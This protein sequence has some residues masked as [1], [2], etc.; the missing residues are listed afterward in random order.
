MVG[1]VFIQ[2]IRYCPYLDRYTSALQAKGIPYDCIWWERWDTP[3]GTP[4]PPQVLAAE[5]RFVFSRASEMAR[6]PI[7]K[8]GDFARFGRFARKIIRER[9][10][11]KL[12]ILTTMSAMILYDLLTGPYRGKYILDIRD[13]SYE[14]LSPFLALEA[15][16]I[17]A[18][19]FTCVS[20][21]GFLDFL[22]KDRPY[23]ITDNF[24]DADREAAAGMRFQK[25]P[26]GE[27][28]V[29]SYLGFIRYFQ[30]GRKILDR[31][32]DDPRFILYY[33]GMGADYDKLVA[34]QQEYHCERLHVTGYFD[35]QRDKHAL[36][37][38]MDILNNFYP[39][40]LELTRLTT[41]NKLYEGIIFR[42]PQVVSTG[43]FMQTLVERWGIGCALDVEDP[44]FADLMYDYYWNL[45]EEAFNRNAEAAL[46]EI[47]GRDNQYRQRV[48]A[49]MDA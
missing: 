15:K 29:L 45:D 25:K 7:F 22:P 35:H 2:D 18:A 34:Y 10:Y 9:R 26:V 49:F 47:I 16:V 21:E 41:G 19:S 28:I 8:M 32:R 39:N 27:P 36:Y 30:E 38:K 3:P 11:E 44:R 46:A 4:L 37:D 33:H 40:T 14:K 13:Y 23:V 1:I 42:R 5:Q 17:D 48:S 31:L 24:T 6:N 12:I 20:S 43:T